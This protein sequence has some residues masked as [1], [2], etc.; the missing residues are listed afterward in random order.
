MGTACTCIKDA[1]ENEIET[2]TKKGN[3]SE[4]A[5]RIQTN[6]RG[7]LAREKYSKMKTQRP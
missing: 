5:L 3:Q 4:M 1:N 2:F 7:K 6:W